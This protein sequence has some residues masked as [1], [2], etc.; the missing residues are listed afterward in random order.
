MLRQCLSLPSFRL[1]CIASLHHLRPREVGGARLTHPPRRLDG[2]NRREAALPCSRSPSAP[3]TYC[4]RLRC[5][6]QSIICRAHAP[7]HGAQ[8]PQ[9]LPLQPP[10]TLQC[11]PS[12]VASNIIT[13]Q[14]GF[15]VATVAVCLWV[16][17]PD[18]SSTKFEV[19]LFVS[20]SPRR[21]A[22]ESTSQA[23]AR[24]SAR[25]PCARARTH[26]PT[27]PRQAHTPRPFV[28]LHPTGGCQSRPSSVT[29][30]LMFAGLSAAGRAVVQAGDRLRHNWWRAITRRLAG[31]AFT[32]C[33]RTFVALLGAAAPN[34][35]TAPSV[36]LDTSILLLA[37]KRCDGRLQRA[38]Y[39]YS[40]GTSVPGSMSSEDPDA[41][42]V[43]D[44]HTL[45]EARFQSQQR[46]TQVLL[47]SLLAL[48][49]QAPL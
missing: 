48:A 31:P 1:L 15:V 36:S 27:P 37:A 14:P 19:S 45:S 16:V 26:P 9:P 32:M 40:C 24:Q 8:G 23:N 38:H 22:C 7:R 47:V 3:R 10:F 33:S 34:N 30:P 25:A 13:S 18:A 35:K 49:L 44:T 43:L 39:L 4:T 42:V 20:F 5:Q 41:E 29:T 11:P 12:S 2:M 28:R 21:A 6:T 46:H 17:S